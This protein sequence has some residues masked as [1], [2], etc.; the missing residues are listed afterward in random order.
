MLALGLAPGAAQAQS[1][2]AGEA[3]S[4][5]PAPDNV[6]EA[7]RLYKLG[8]ARYEL[9]DF[10]AAIQYWTEAY[11]LVPEGDAQTHRVRTVLVRNLSVAHLKAFDVD[12]DP[13][14]LRTGKMLLE[15][16]IKELETYYPDESDSQKELKEAQEQLA[17]IEAKLAKIEEETAEQGGGGGEQGGGSQGGGNQGGGEQGGGNQGG[18]SQ[19]G[20][21][22][23]GP[24]VDEE[25]MRKGK[26]L[27]LTGGVVLGVVG[28]GA[29]VGLGVTGAFMGNNA[30]EQAPEVDVF[31]REAL[32]ERGRT[33]NTLAYT[34]L[35]V[36]AVGI[37]TGATLLAIG[38][39]KKK[40]AS[41]P[42]VSVIPSLS[43]RNAGA[44][45]AL[46]F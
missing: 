40:E 44:Q 28:I 6:S 26:T 42:R 34:G 27:M 37:I 20:G 13:V 11:A 14:H 12:Q 35:A 23:P 46:E 33:G 24:V 15:R 16:Y 19:G 38:A 18:G 31:D 36:G 29:G 39:K 17:E 21:T 8:E 25:G 45:I 9:F 22:D 7:Q 32:L 2:A 5:A 43:P 41:Q 10:A 1:P 30:N 3:P 4:E